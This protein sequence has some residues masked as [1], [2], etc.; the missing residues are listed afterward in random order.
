MSQ[1]L[2]LLEAEKQF[3]PSTPKTSHLRRSTA[4]SQP[5]SRLSPARVLTVHL[6][7]Q[8]TSARAS[9]LSMVSFIIC[10]R[11]SYLRKGN[12]KTDSWG[13]HCPYSSIA[14]RNETQTKEKRMRLTF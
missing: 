8:S 3:L 14:G 1:L 4:T 11:A 12:K 9:V 2:L 6:Q 7:P 10:G 13:D 5:P